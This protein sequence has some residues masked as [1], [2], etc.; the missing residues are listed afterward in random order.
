MK[1]FKNNLIKIILAS[2]LFPVVL[3]LMSL[4]IR[5]QSANSLWQALADFVVFVAAFLLN[6][7]YLK[8][9]VSWL[10]NNHLLAQLSTALPAIIIVAF[11]NSPMLAV[12]D[13]KVKFSVIFVCLL[14]G[15]AEEYIFRGLLVSLFLK[16]LHNN[17]FGAVIG[18]SVMFG[19]IHLMNLKSLSFGYVSAQVI[20]A[21]AI[22]ILFATIYV[23]THN[24]AIVI[25]LHAL[26][27]M[28]PMFSD[29]MMAQAAKTSF[30]IA[31]IYVM[32]FFL[33]ITLT[34]AYFQL[35][36]FEINEDEF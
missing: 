16:L 27:D 5:K 10:N 32:V 23:K 13:F 34:I 36:N 35:Q 1:F 20:F 26:R 30:S 18:S 7:Y 3:N 9:K 25:A 2:L 28:F 4:V 14:V 17:V 11:L 8:Q 29:K 24:L 19:L 31:S 6:R 33:L 12:T 21:I 15:L 22:G